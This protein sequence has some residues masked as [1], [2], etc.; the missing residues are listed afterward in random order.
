MPEQ[1]GHRRLRCCSRCMLGQMLHVV[2]HNV[3]PAICVRAEDCG[4]GE[5]TMRR[6]FGLHGCALRAGAWGAGNRLCLEL[7]VLYCSRTC[8]QATDELSCIILSSHTTFSEGEALPDKL[9]RCSGSRHDS[10][11]RMH[12]RANRCPAVSQAIFVA[13]RHLLAVAARGAPV[14]VLYAQLTSCHYLVSVVLL[15]TNSRQSVT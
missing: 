10:T 14:A 5:G 12:R 11:L 3:A 8:L 1:V 2:T 9:P 4:H 13:A 6:R 15:L 7:E